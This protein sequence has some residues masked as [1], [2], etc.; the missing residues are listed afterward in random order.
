MLGGCSVAPICRQAEG[1]AGESNLLSERLLF[2]FVISPPFQMGAQRG[3]LAWGPFLE[4]GRAGVPISALGPVALS[5]WFLELQP[6]RS[7]AE[8]HS[9]VGPEST[10]AP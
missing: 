5:A 2:N 9:A 3:F 6:V 10:A 8:L 4:H 1:R 7:G